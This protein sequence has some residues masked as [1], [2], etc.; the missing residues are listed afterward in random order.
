MPPRSAPRR[1]GPSWSER[2]S[3]AVDL[4]D[5]EAARQCFAEAVREDRGNPMHRYHLA[6]VQEALGE[7]GRPARA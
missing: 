2:G 6:V 4:G 1:L 7:L 3:A 5:L